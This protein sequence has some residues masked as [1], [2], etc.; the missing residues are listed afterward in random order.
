MKYN[1]L[2][3]KYE[4]YDVEVNE[5]LKRKN[6]QIEKLLKDNNRLNTEVRLLQ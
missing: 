4:K 1:K 2:K 6:S 5:A 3:S